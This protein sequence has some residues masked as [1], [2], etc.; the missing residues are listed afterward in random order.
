MYLGEPGHT[1]LYRARAL[2]KR[3]KRINLSVDHGHP[4]PAAAAATPLLPPHNLA[5]R[6]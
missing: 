4:G 3:T 6:T 2:T 1:L 5:Q